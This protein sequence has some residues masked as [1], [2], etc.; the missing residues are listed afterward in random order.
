MHT[1]ILYKK[2]KGKKIDQVY[3]FCQA[4]KRNDRSWS[5]QRARRGKYVKRCVLS[6]YKFHYIGL[7]KSKASL[8]ATSDRDGE[9]QLAANKSK[10]MKAKS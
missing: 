3:V 10:L 2:R 9:S 6:L 8:R 5:K 4:D 1:F 7:V